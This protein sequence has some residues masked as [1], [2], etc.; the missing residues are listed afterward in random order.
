MA[1]KRINDTHVVDEETGEVIESRVE[2]T[3][4]FLD[5]II[6]EEAKRENLAFVPG[7]GMQAIGAVFA[8]PDAG[9]PPEPVP[10]NP[11]EGGPASRRVKTADRHDEPGEPIILWR[12]KLRSASEIEDEV[13]REIQ[14]IIDQK[15]MIPSDEG[16]ELDNIR[17]GQIVVGKQRR[18]SG[19]GGAEYLDVK[20]RLVWIRDEEPDASIT[21]EVVKLDET[22]AV[23]KATVTILRYVIP[24]GEPTKIL[25]VVSTGYGSETPGDFGDYI[26][27]AETK[28]IG[29]ALAVAGYGAQYMPDDA[30]VVDSPVERNHNTPRTQNNVP[31]RDE[32]GRSGIQGSNA[33]QARVQSE[34]RA[35]VAAVDVERL[36][37]LRREVIAERDRVGA[38]PEQL[39]AIVVELIGDKRPEQ[40]TIAN[41]EELLRNLSDT[42][43]GLYA[44]DGA[45]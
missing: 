11:P 25:N 39:N 24:E 1:R 42:P 34:N 30:A 13:E 20:W 18:L 22:I 7:E 45:P 43:N 4:I 37:K 6:A 35:S 14:R 26:E 8:P 16:A 33:E 38:T 28:A 31:P 29:R 3:K 19:R 32:T 10:Y 2:A 40:L 27:K 15:A 21:T 5:E 41:L 9:D 44:A 17:R 23:F 12:G 36:K